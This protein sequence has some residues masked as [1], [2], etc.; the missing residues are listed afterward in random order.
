MNFFIVF[1]FFLKYLANAEKLTTEELN[2]LLL[3]TGKK[4]RTVLHMAAEYN[5]L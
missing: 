3:V 5:E 4:G 2:K 1:P